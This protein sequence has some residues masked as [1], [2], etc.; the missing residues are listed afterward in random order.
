MTALAREGVPLQP[1]AADLADSKLCMSR[2]GSWPC[3]S[4]PLLGDPGNAHTVMIVRQHHVMMHS[5]HMLTHVRRG[6]TGCQERRQMPNGQRQ[7][8]RTLYAPQQQMDHCPGQRIFVKGLGVQAKAPW[9]LSRWMHAWQQ[10]GAAGSL[11]CSGGAERRGRVRHVKTPRHG[12]PQ[13]RHLRWRGLRRPLPGVPV[14]VPDRGVGHRSVREDLDPVRALVS[15]QLRLARS[16]MC[17]LSGYPEQTG[18]M[19]QQSACAHCE[20]YTVAGAAL[21][22]MRQRSAD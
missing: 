11:T 21:T 3:A 13:R 15:P 16:G 17:G 6:W 12:R 14:L 20:L 19:C 2:L 1:D 4:S 10:A 9:D 22:A 5:H 8:S 18:Q 7:P